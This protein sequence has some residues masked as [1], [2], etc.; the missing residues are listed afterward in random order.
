[1]RLSLDII[2]SY[3]FQERTYK[4][5]WDDV[6]I[7]FTLPNGLELDGMIL[8]NNQ[9]SSTSMLEGLDGYI[10]IETKEELDELVGMTYE[11]V[12]NKIA[13]ENHDFD[14]YSHIDEEE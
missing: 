6:C 10:C 8:C 2:R 12:I 9:P 1:M 5:D 13:A 14:K 4:T 11:E 7:E 3:G